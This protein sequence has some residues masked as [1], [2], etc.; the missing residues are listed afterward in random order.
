MEFEL[1]YTPEQE[2]F[3]GEVRAW[4]QANVPPG[5]NR[6]PK[7]WE[8]SRELYDQRRALGRKLGAK[9][10]LYPSGEKKYGG[11]GLG[12]DQI[13]VLEE[14]S[15]SVG[16]TL[17][18]YYDSGGRMGGASIRVWGTD[19][20]KE[21]FLR[22]IYTGQWRSWQLLT[23]PTAGSDLA[24]VKMTAIR[25]GDVYVFNGQKIYVGSHHG[26]EMLWTIAVTDPKGKRHQNV[27]WFVIDASLPGI[28]IQA[29]PMLSARSEGDTDDFA[30][31]NI[32]YFDNVRV[33]ADCL[34]GGENN[35]W[36][37]ASTHLEV[38]HGGQGN[39][40]TNPVW[41]ALLQHCRTQHRDGRRL[42]D[43]PDLR[44]KLAE[45]YSRLEAVRLLATRNFWMVYSGTKRSYEGSQTSYLRKTTNLWL[46]KALL[47]LLGPEAM[48][49]DPL[50]G[51]MQ[52]FSE[53]HQRRGIVE[54]HPGGTT[55]IQRVIIARR[56]GVGA[57]E[58]E[59][60]GKLGEE[61]TLS[62][63]ATREA[64]EG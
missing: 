21:R 12:F 23:E 34:V 64:A 58:R 2:K 20:Q 59:Q 4:L 11:G 38:E 28:T 57:R 49:T 5:M 46:T 44:V 22:P 62:K 33:P 45:I 26:A 6:S 50:R 24:G 41:T 40:R 37:V 1:K 43:D 61:G 17:P 7:T 47:D 25:D 32:V 3:R 42:I 29:L 60:A 27:S 16:I 54:Q 36:K 52:G 63:T 30:H 9:G 19:E 39:I 53:S 10:W 13:V 31:K 8:E 51:A 18:P 56:L 48:S 15:A 35:G 14:E 55:D